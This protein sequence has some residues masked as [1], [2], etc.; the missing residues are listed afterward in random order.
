MGDVR[1][2]GWCGTT[3]AAFVTAVATTGSLVSLVCMGVLIG[4]RGAGGLG[5]SATRCLALL[6]VVVWATC[7]WLP[8]AMRRLIERLA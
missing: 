7:W 2:V 3:H 8:D 1:H 4:L 6:H 5:A